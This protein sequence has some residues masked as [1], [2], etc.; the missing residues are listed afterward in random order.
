MGDNYPTVLRISSGGSLDAA[1]PFLAPFYVTNA[2]S[3]LQVSIDPANGAVKQLQKFEGLE[4]V[5][6]EETTF[7]HRL[8]NFIPYNVIKLSSGTMLEPLLAMH[9][10]SRLFPMGHIKSV[11]TNDEAFIEKFSKSRKWLAVHSASSKL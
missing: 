8:G 11:N 1:L 5:L 7:E 2:R 10:V 3:Q 4:V 9:W 6:E